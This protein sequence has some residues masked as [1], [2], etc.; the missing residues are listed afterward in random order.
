MAA[1]PGL[2]A[3]PLADLAGLDD[4]A[5]RTLFAGT[6]VKRTG[7]DR[8]LRNVLIAVGN[9]GDPTLAAAA[10]RCLTDPAALVRGMAVWACNAL[11][12]AAACRPLYERFGIGETD[13]HVRAEWS[14][15]LA[16]PGP[17]ETA[18]P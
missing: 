14:A 3:P 4:A 10:E 13:D 6:P 15:A 8:F 11:L 16:D 5:F 1:M 17:M 2:A 12:G 18:R 7:R 9:S